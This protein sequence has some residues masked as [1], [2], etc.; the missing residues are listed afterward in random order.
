M[1]NTPSPGPNDTDSVTVRLVGGPADWHEATLDIYTA[2]DLAAPREELG[3]YLISTG[4]PAGHPDPAARADYS[5]NDEPWPAHIWFFRGW[6]PYS[7]GDPEAGSAEHHHPVEMV[8]DGDGLPA[9]WTDHTGATHTVDRVLVHWQSTGEDH[10]APDVW[11]VE[12][13]SPHGSGVWELRHHVGDMWEAGPIY[14][15]TA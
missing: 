8:V 13:T 1:T 10:L 9:R 11:Q 4:V 14:G 7:P 5:P 12:A 3:T 6:I 15:N 2:E